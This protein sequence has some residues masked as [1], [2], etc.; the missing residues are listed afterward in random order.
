MS[1]PIRDAYTTVPERS[2]GW[3]LAASVGSVLSAFIASACCAGPLVFELL[4]VTGF[5]F[6]V[7]FEPYRPY[8]VASTVAL[9]GTGFYLTYRAR[10]ATNGPESAAAECGCQARRTHHAGKIT[11]WIA[12]LLALGFLSFSYTAPWLFG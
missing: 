1:E 4:G 6:L 7:K 2:R 9:L 8:F 12:T 10:K 3:S 11:L 5:G